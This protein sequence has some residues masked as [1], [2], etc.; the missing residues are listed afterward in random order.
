MRKCSTCIII[1]GHRTLF[2]VT[3]TER[4]EYGIFCAPYNLH[5]SMLN[6]YFYFHFRWKYPV[7]IYLLK[8]NNRNT[9]KRCEICSK[10]T[11]KTRCSSVS[12]VN[13]EH[14]NT[15]WDGQIL[16]NL[17]VQSENGEMWNRKKSVFRPYMYMHIHF[18]KDIFCHLIVIFCCF[19]FGV[20]LVHGKCYFCSSCYNDKRLL[21]PAKC[22]ND[23]LFTWIYLNV[24]P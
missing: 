18:V 11:I 10:L 8:V 1:I 13:F 21:F 19:S 6:K 7:G 23:A 15:R 17:F 22:Q 16:L 4:C 9:K 20:H 2:S 3:A 5:V 12:I 24:T 14:V